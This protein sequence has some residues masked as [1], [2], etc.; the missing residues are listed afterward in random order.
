VLVIDE[1]GVGIA[2]VLDHVGPQVVADGVG[3]PA[4]AAQQPLHP[5]WA[6]FPQRLRQLPAVAPLHGGQQPGQV[7]PG[8]DP[9][10]GPPEVRGDAVLHGAQRVLPRRD[11][12]SWACSCGVS[13]IVL[14]LPPCLT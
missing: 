12:A 5:V 9:H 6:P 7:A 10:L 13:A 11:L 4:C 1:H 8:A 14:L 2:Q 3:I